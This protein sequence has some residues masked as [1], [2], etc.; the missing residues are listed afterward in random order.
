MSF[1]QALPLVPIAVVLH[2]LEAWPAFP[3]WARR[4][5]SPDYSDGDDVVTHALAVPVLLGLRDGLFT[6]QSLTR[7]VTAAGTFH[8]IEIGHT[9][10]RRW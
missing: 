4:F 5:A 7:A 6:A 10:F 9:E 1:S 2:I 3:R 8:T